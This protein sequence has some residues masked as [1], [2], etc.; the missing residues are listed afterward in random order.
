MSLVAEFTVPTEALPF[1]PALE[2][3]SDLRI[4]LDRIVP[5]DEAAFPYF[6]VVSEDP[7]GFLDAARRESDV[8]AVTML[9]EM[10]ERALFRAVW[11]PDAELIR[12]ID[13][14]EG[15]IVEA[16]GTSERW[17]FEIR[18]QERAAFAKFQQ[19]FSQR[20]IPIQ[21]HRLYDLAEFV[22][23]DQAPITDAQREALITAYRQGYYDEPRGTTQRELGEG[24]GVSSRAVSDRLR[25]G[26]RNLIAAT[27]VPE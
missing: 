5:T 9:E 21:L 18:A 16:V 20:Q 23:G 25:R 7:E 10:R 24:F 27:L 14:L 13:G 17:R 12:A 1:R 8:E 4:E 22:E 19:V 26:T 6:W 11:S 15:T 3:T 2:S